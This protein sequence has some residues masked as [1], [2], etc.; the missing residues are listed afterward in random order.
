MSVRRPRLPVRHRCWGFCV[1]VSAGTLSSSENMQHAPVSQI[2]PLSWASST[3]RHRNAH[4]KDCATNNYKESR[5]CLCYWTHCLQ[6]KDWQNILKLMGLF[7]FISAC[8]VVAKV[9]LQLNLLP[10]RWQWVYWMY[11]ITRISAM[12]THSSNSKKRYFFCPLMVKKDKILMEGSCDMW[13][14]L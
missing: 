9:K 4:A 6:Q 1:R 3:Q 14:F 11:C 10:A 2:Q 5:K 13:H 7:T 12:E 8:L